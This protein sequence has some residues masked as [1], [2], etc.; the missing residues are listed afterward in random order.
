MKLTP[1]VSAYILNVVK[2]AKLVGID[3]VII[4]PGN[5][6]AMDEASTIVIFQDSNVMDMPFESIGLTRLDGLLARYNV[7]SSGDN[8]SVEAIP[9]DNSNFARSI[10]MKS[11]GTKVDYRCGDPNN[12]K[13]PRQIND[14]RTLEVQLSSTAVDMLHSGS[15]A[16]GADIVT[17][18]S[19]DDGVRFT[20]MDINNDSFSHT[21]ADTV[22]QLDSDVSTQFVHKYPVKMLLSIFKQNPTGKFAVG[23]KGILSFVV[24][25]LTLYVLPK[26]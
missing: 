15:A 7:A 16:M 4:E 20:L 17:I 25:G 26:V 21:F 19:D 11:K 13:A 8:F 12:I 24:N 10:I 6:R 1:E 3:S 14:E 9:K 5:V 22:D 23:N 18:I 2:T